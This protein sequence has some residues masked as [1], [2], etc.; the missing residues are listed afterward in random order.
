MDITFLL[1]SRLSPSMDELDF[2]L[3]SL[4]YP[5]GRLGWSQG[6]GSVLSSCFS[7][8]Q[9]PLSFSHRRGSFQTLSRLVWALGQEAGK[10][11]VAQ[12]VLQLQGLLSLQWAGLPYIRQG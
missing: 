9:P 4:S 3:L 10:V 12:L 7:Q 11:R 6:G 1:S 2:F 5:G 8:T